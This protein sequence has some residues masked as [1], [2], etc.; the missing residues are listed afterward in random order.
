MFYLSSVFHGFGHIEEVRI[1]KEKG[2]G[3][4]KFQTHD[5]ATRSI[6]TVNG[7]NI[8]G[9]VVRVSKIFHVNQN[10]I[11]PKL[12]VLVFLGQGTISFWSWNS[13]TSPGVWI[14]PVRPKLHVQYALPLPICLLR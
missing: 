12:C 13:S 14:L 5:Q 4:V 3:F 8:V 2:F 7:T 1:Q 11:K 9:R 6:I 10:N